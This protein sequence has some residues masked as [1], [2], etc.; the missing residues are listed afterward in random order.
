MNP[1]THGDV[2]YVDALAVKAGYNAWPIRPMLRKL[3]DDGYLSIEG[4]I[5]EN[6]YPTVAALRWQDLKLTPREAKAIVRGLK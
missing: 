2:G 5:A 6:V 3:I 4:D 1:A